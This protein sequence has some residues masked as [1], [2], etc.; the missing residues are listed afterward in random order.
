METFSALLAICAGHSPVPGEIP[1]KRPVTQSFDVFFDL[2][3]NKRFSKQSWGWWFETLSRTLWRHRDGRC[4]RHACAITKQLENTVLSLRDFARCQDR[5]Y[6]V[7]LTRS[8]NAFDCHSSLR[9]AQWTSISVCL[10][11]W[12]TNIV[13]GRRVQQEHLTLLSLNIPDNSVQ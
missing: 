6:C 2:R 9:N 5:T 10:K 12:R 1:A 4:S 13:L 7:I 8:H 11:Y 3:L